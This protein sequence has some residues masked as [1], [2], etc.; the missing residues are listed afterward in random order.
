MFDKK[1][2]LKGAI[3][4]VIPVYFIASLFVPLMS[5]FS[6]VNG[7]KHSFI[8]TGALIMTHKFKND[9]F[10]KG[11]RAF[12]TKGVGSNTLIELFWYCMMIQF[13]MSVILL[14]GIAIFWLSGKSKK[15]GYNMI[16]LSGIL[17]IAAMVGQLVLVLI[18]KIKLPSSVNFALNYNI[19]FVIITVLLG[20]CFVVV[21]HQMKKNFKEPKLRK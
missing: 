2:K 13:I 8:S 6:Y 1:F 17:Y 18:A 15:T 12:F 9:P 10:G 4:S 16:S 20:A 21:S 3:L 7:G 14:I 5:L 19:P 11:L